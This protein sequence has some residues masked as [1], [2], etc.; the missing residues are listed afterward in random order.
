MATSESSCVGLHGI[1]SPALGLTP[2]RHSENAGSLP[3]S[4]LA[5]AFPTTTA[6]ERPCTL[7]MS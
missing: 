3:Q 4:V 7:Y 1:W 2:A 5:G 6:P